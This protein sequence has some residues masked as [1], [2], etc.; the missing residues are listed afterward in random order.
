MRTYLST[1][2]DPIFNVETD[3]ALL[4]GAQACPDP[5]WRIT[6]LFP[7]GGSRTE[8][9]MWRSFVPSLQYSTVDCIHASADRA[10]AI[11]LTITFS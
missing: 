1:L 10:T 2:L 7:Y 4:F 11:S 5:V 9:R 6:N 8:R 3:G